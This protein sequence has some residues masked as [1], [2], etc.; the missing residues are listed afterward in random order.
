MGAAASSSTQRRASAGPSGAS[1]ASG[2]AAQQPQQAPGP[3]TVR[4]IVPPGM[5]PGQMAAFTVNGRT[6]RAVIPPGA[7]PGSAFKRRRASTE[8]RLIF[9]PMAVM[10]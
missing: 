5:R 10:K 2:A 7:E 1:P 3:Q 4:V 6:L 9:C 8:R